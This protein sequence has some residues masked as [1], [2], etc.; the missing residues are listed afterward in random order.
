[1]FKQTVLFTALA[2]LALTAV[3][4]DGSPIFVPNASFETIYKPGST[5]ITAEVPGN[6]WTNGTGPN[7]PMNGS[8]LANYSDNTTGEFVDIPGWVNVPGWEANYGWVENA[9]GVIAQQS[10]AFDGDYY[11]SGNGSNWGNSQGAATQS[12]SALTTI[13]A[14]TDYTASMQV[15]G[16]VTPVF[17]TLLADDVVIAPSSTVGQGDTSTWTTVSA[18]Y[19]AGDLAAYVGQEL[20]IR[21]GWGDGDLDAENGQA[22][23]TQSRLDLVTLTAV[24]E[25]GS[26]ALLGL[27]GLLI[28]RRRR[29]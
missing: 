2:G 4:A 14:G 23:G 22:V 27:G 24:P 28:A 15:I 12:A 11:Y 25:P 5:T 6:T 20:K 19:L 10:A 8:S 26:L 17:I 21:V 3:Q 1:M 9:A 18:T 16:G 13:A 7:A 29:S